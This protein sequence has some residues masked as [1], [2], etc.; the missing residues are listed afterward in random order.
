MLGFLYHNT[1]EGNKFVKNR[2]NNI[3]DNLSCLNIDIS[4]SDEFTE[5]KIIELDTHNILWSIM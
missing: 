3:K 2:Y 1:L 4:K 5:R